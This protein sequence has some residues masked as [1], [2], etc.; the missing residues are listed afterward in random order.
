MCAARL[1]QTTAFSVQV[2]QAGTLPRG[3]RAGER[4]LQRRGVIHGQCPRVRRQ[5]RGQQAVT[6]TGNR[7]TLGDLCRCRVQ[8]VVLHPRQAAVSVVSS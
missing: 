5:P 2:V 4:Q 3:C 8:D 7:E 1:R 6:H